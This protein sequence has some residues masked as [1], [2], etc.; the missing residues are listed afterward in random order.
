DGA[1]NGLRDANAKLTE[2]IERERR[3]E[4]MRRRFVS[5]VSHELKNPISMI[6]A[7]A[8]GLRHNIAKDPEAM[9]EYA[10][11]I[12]DESDKMASLIK[13]LLDL[14][15][16]ESG[17]FTI[18]KAWFDFASLVKESSERQKKLFDEKGVGLE[19]RLPE[20]AMIYGDALRMEQILSNFL[21]NALRH[22][23]EGGKVKVS[24]ENSREGS[25][26]RVY[27][28]G[29]PIEENEI[30]N[31]WTSF[32]KIRNSGLDPAAGTG[33]GLAIVRA[34]VDLHGG[35]YGVGNT[36]KGVAFWVEIPNENTK[37]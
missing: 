3:L 2:D 21:A 1:L 7:Y 11:I 29:S 5:S 14:S 22:S 20:K 15:A 37:E 10:E 36:E 6:Q 34:I 12:S 25:R 17:T 23:D 28:T 30:E 35:S 13:D 16:Y 27:N 33:L 4:K 19:T 26:L 31:I 9:A 32:Y 18:N 24:L 8:D